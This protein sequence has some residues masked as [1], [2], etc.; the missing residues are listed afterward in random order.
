MKGIAKESMICKNNV[1]GT[2]ILNV[3][4]KKKLVIAYSDQGK[5]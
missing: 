4:F 1:F 5:S 2:Y 3:V